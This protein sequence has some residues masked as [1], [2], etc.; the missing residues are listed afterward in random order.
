MTSQTVHNLRFSAVI[1]LAAGYGW[2][3][4][5]F[6][7]VNSP[8]WAYFFQYVVLGLLLFLSL[9]FFAEQQTQRKKKIYFLALSIFT[10]ITGVL[11]IIN[12]LHGFNNATSFGSHNTLS[13]IIPLAFLLLGSILWLITLVSAKR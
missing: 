8:W 9:G 10:A 13:D 3:G 1:L 12:L 4:G 2:A 5:H 6:Y 7:P 11:N